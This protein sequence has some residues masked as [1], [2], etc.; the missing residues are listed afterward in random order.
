MPTPLEKGTMREN[1]ITAT[2]QTLLAFVFVTIGFALGKEV[3]LRRQGSANP[4]SAPEPGTAKDKVIVTYLHT[5]FRCETCNTIERL[6]KALV[7]TEFGSERTAGRIEWRVADFQK[8][9][10]IA[11]RYE[12]VSSCVVVARVR[13]GRETDYQRLDDVWVHYKNPADFNLYVG[14]AIRK[15]LGGLE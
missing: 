10:A 15:G 12:V 9:E 4:G 7:D 5:T 1:L 13:D 14:A 6:A 2:K 3:T 8:D 11:K